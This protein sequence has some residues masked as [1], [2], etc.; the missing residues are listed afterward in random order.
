MRYHNYPIP[1]QDALD[2]TPAE[3]KN[4]QLFNVPT[5]YT[6]RYKFVLNPSQEIVDARTQIYTAFQSA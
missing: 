1:I 3:L 6:D 4:D 5:N 2:Q